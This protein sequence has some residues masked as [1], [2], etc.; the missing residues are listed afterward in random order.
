MSIS[1]N[2]A[3]VHDCGRQAN[4]KKICV[5]DLVNGRHNQQMSKK[6]ITVDGDG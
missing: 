6:N 5:R 4:D 3:L 2:Q 1:E